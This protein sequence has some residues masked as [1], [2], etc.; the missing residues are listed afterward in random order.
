MNKFENA[1]GQSANVNAIVRHFFNLIGFLS[2]H[3][4]TKFLPIK[5]RS[6]KTI[7]AKFATGYAFNDYSLIKYFAP[8]RVLSN[9]TTF[10]SSKGFT[11][12]CA[13][14]IFIL[15][16]FAISCILSPDSLFM[17]YIISSFKLSM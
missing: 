7:I 2:F 1:T 12:I 10:V 11:I 16:I 3:I 9:F 17:R 13:I 5:M 8:L 15:M 6:D 14:L 4:Y